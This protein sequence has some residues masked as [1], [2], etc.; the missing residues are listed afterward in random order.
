[1]SSYSLVTAP[2]VEPLT[3]SEAKLFLRVDQT[4][5]DALITAMIVAARQWVENFT[6]RPLCSQTWKLNLNDDEITE[7]LGINKGPVQSIT[8]IK[9]F[10]TLNVQNTMA[11]GVYQQD[12]LNE[13]AIIRITTMPDFYD[14]LNAMEIQFVCG[15]GVAAS[16]P[17]AIKQAMY[18]M[19]GHWYEH[20]ESVSVG[21]FTEVPV[22]SQALLEPY[23][24]TFFYPYN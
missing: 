19:L 13:P 5:E 2:T 23:K 17:D 16:V 7:F 21:N 1:M 14:R 4:T 3:L 18:L 15:Y 12:L 10:D 11:T 22:T 8:H 24:N 20:R 9:Y 6:W